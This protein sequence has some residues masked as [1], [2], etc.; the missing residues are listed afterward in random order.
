MTRGGRSRMTTDQIVSLGPELAAFLAGYADCFRRI[1]PRRKLETY[2]RGRLSEV[3]RKSV[4]PIA[5]A[6]G[7]KP[8]TLQEFLASDDWDEDRLA[9]RVQQTGAG[10]DADGPATG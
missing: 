5:L 1:E 10:G 8:R 2:V 7:T 9:A 4:E 6:A 3:P